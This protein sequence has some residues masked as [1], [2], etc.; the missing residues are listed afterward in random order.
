MRLKQ[1]RCADRKQT[2]K[3]SKSFHWKGWNQK[4]FETWQ[5]L[6]LVFSFLSLILSL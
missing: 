2:E 5:A 4:R 3:S 6:V 1:D